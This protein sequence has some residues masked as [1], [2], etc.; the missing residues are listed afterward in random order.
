MSRPHIHL[1]IVV[2]NFIYRIDKERHNLFQI[3]SI[4]KQ[5]NV[6]SIRCFLVRRR[7]LEELS[8]NV[9]K[10]QTKVLYHCRK[11]FLKRKKKLL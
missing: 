3:L 1:H 2:S 6:Y 9:L 4:Y 7:K 11:R 5:R 8:N 10:L